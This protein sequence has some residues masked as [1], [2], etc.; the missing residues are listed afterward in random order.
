MLDKDVANWERILTEAITRKVEPNELDF[1]ETLSEDTD[2][3]K[4]HI[5]AMGNLEGGGIFVFGVTNNFKLSNR[6]IAHE[7]VLKRMT[8]LAADSQSPP[9]KIRPLTL[10]SP[11]LGELFAIHVMQ[12]L[13][14][15]VFIRDRSPWGGNG[16]FK[17]SGGSTLSMT[18]DEIRELLSRSRSL[19]LDDTCVNDVG[20]EDLD[21]AAIEK[22]L[23]LFSAMDGL[24]IKNMSILKEQHIICGELN[25]CMVTLAGWLVF[26]KNP[27]A[28]RTFRNAAIEFQQFRGR[29][30]D[31]P[32]KKSVVS[33]ALPAQIDAATALLL[34]HLWVMPKIKGTRREDI[35]AYDEQILR[36]LITN[37]VMHRDYSKMHQPIKIAMF[38]DRLEIENPGGLV[39]GLTIW[40]LVNKRAWRNPKLAELLEKTG[41]CEMDG[42]GIDRILAAT[43][44]IRLPAPLFVSD[45]YSFRVTLSGP[46]SYQ[47]F[48]HEERKATV[49]SIIILD[50]EVDNES[51][52]NTFDISAEQA[53]T[54]LKS[55]V[56]EQII[57]P[58][59]NVR[60][61]KF[62]RYV[63]TPIVRDKIFG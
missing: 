2:R 33:G 58:A 56:A 8:N 17:R 9:L 15:P 7:E 43:R 32:L 20:V 38:T 3:L 31:E 11:T 63:L 35:P 23:P 18:D 37:A 29:V 30:R 6:Q 4:E 46:K 36:E 26:A 21:F 24:S 10:K 45:Q 54:L 55:L 51:I 13:T 12:G 50:R 39:P 52:R 41:H 22:A 60:S 19:S 28:K 61:K 34:Q 5:N 57:E 53:G 49:I 47:Y 16:C 1:K 62:A 44:K 59:D 42:Q 27:Q 14:L 48:T 40:N 25:N